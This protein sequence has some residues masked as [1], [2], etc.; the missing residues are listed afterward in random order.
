MELNGYQKYK[1]QSVNTMTKSEMLILLL[2]ELVKRILRAEMALIKKDYELFDQSVSRSIE[3][4]SYLKRTLNMDYE[5]SRN[6]SKMYD[7]FIYELSRLSSSRNQEILT[8]IKPLI[9]ELRTAFREASKKV[10][11]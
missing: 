2:D 5:I 8:E 4:V 7:F 3:I 9:E 11:N 10:Q 6:L 1:E